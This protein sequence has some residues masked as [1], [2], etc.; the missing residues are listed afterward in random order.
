[1]DEQTR[2]N[3]DEVLAR[4]P[5]RTQAWVELDAELPRDGPELQRFIGETAREP[6]N[7]YD[8]CLI[9]SSLYDIFVLAKAAPTL[10]AAQWRDERVADHLKY[11]FFDGAVLLR[12]VSTLCEK[13]HI[14]S[15]GLSKLA[16]KWRAH[17]REHSD[18]KQAL[19]TLYESIDRQEVQDIFAETTARLLRLR[20]PESIKIQQ[21]LAAGLPP[22]SGVKESVERES[23]REVRRRDRAPAAK[24]WI[25]LSD[26]VEKYDVPRA[27]LQDFVSHFPSDHR[28]KDA[29][30]GQVRVIEA[31]LRKALKN[32]GRLKA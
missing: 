1:M 26:A 25:Y 28:V 24:G 31:E 20:D 18:P 7:A 27:T 11:V 30:S 29:D 23:G 17:W 19:I 10:T 4:L 16:A 32:K 21:G 12:T 3:L 22:A 6:I 15:A 8:E 9:V 13:Y 14:P 2:E 5:I